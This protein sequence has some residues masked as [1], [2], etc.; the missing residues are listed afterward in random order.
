M[1]PRVFLL[2]L[3]LMAEAQITTFSLNDPINLIAPATTGDG[4]TVVF[5]A[6]RAPDGTALTATNL[7]VFSLATNLPIHQLT[8]YTGTQTWTGVTSVACG[9]GIAAYAAAPGGPGNAE[10]V[11]FI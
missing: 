9:P 4:S 11:H 10:E 5:A 7:F 3:P 1:R 8:N 2:L 6:A